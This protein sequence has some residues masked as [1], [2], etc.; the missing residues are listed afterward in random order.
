MRFL[1]PLVVL[2]LSLP[3]AARADTPE[4]AATPAVRV[5]PDAPAHAPPPPQHVVHG[6]ITPAMHVWILRGSG[7]AGRVRSLGHLDVE[8]VG[9]ADAAIDALQSRA[10]ALHADAVIQVRVEHG[11]RGTTRVWGLAIR[12]V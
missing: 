5:G 1:A 9:D 7:P 11:A 12:Y 4:L 2:A 6:P 8:V 10:W 3:T